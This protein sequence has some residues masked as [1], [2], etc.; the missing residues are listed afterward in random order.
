MMLVGREKII[1]TFKVLSIILLA[2]MIV[3]FYSAIQNETPNSKLENPEQRCS[4]NIKNINLSIFGIAERNSICDKLTNEKLD[5]NIFIQSTVYY[6]FAIFLGAF[7]NAKKIM[8]IG[9]I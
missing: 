4:Q 5:S 6:S 1:T 2:Y 7:I 3:D 9:V 8:M